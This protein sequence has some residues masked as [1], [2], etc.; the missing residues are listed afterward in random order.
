[1]FDLRKIEY[2]YQT[3]TQN[4]NY[5]LPDG[6]TVI[7][8][9][10]VDEMGILKTPE[11]ERTPAIAQYFH[12]V[13]SIDKIT[14]IN[15]DFVVWIVPELRKKEKPVTYTLIALNKND[16][17]KLELGF[18]VT[19]QSSSSWVVLKILENYLKEIKETESTMHHFEDDL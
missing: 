4:L 13:E 14:L 11:S 17:P 2:S 10:A 6:L 12:V 19:D 5:W 3:F 9:A 15:Q 18:A 1:M 16:I 8:D 7:D